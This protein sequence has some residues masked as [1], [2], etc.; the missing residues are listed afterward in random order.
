MK[1]VNFDY[2]RPRDIADA[3]RALAG[4][5]GEG[6]LISGGQSLGPIIV[7]L[8]LSMLGTAA[9]MAACALM[10]AATGIVVALLFARL[11]AGKA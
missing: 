6:K 3:V 11:D 2:V 5:D 4:S 9:T 7:G 1:P 10:F 8:L